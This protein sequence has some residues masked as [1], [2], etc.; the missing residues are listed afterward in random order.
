MKSLK[1]TRLRIIFCFKMIHSGKEVSVLKVAIATNKREISG[2]EDTIAALYE[3]IEELREANEDLTTRMETESASACTSILNEGAIKRGKLDLK[4]KEARKEWLKHV[5]DGAK[6]WIVLKDLG[7]EFYRFDFNNGAF[8]VS[9]KEIGAWSV[10]C[11]CGSLDIVEKGDRWCYNRYSF[12][13][14]VDWLTRHAKEI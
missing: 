8:L 11:L 3:D 13:Q 4:N 7:R 10:E 12:P 6:P 2:Y 9:V 1:K 5:F 14:V